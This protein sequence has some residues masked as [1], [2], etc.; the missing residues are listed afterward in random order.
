M[1]AGSASPNR[2]P[3]I[4]EIPPPEVMLADLLV[5]ATRFIYFMYLC[6][7]I[8]LCINYN[9]CKDLFEAEVQTRIEIVVY[10]GWGL[11]GVYRGCMRHYTNIIRKRIRRRRKGENTNENKN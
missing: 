11:Y 8:L 7:L 5:Y 9:I 10:I 3:N 4:P 1:E 2:N 6:M